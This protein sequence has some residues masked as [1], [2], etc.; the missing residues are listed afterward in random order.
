MEKQKPIAT[1]VPST[2]PMT[3][4]K[5]EE[6]TDA[7]EG[8]EETQEE[9]D[10]GDTQEEEEEESSPAE[11]QSGGEKPEYEV[12]AI[13]DYVKDDS[14]SLVIHD[15][16]L[17]GRGTMYIT[18]VDLMKDWERFGSHFQI[19]ISLDSHKPAIH[20]DLANPSR[21]LRLVTDF[22]KEGFRKISLSLYHRT[23]V[24]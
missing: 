22:Q 8:E 1:V 24:L 12:E 16:C 5:E 18:I 21:V 7:E 19:R 6:T 2:D 13:V 14:V 11:E 10:V 23:Q 9:D 17:F 3:P 4:Q 15:L 20:L